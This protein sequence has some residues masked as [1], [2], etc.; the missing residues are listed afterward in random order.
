[1][2]SFCQCGVRISVHSQAFSVLS[3]Y[4]FASNLRRSIMALIESTAVR[5][6]LTCWLHSSILQLRRR[7]VS[8]HVNCLTFV[9]TISYSGCW[10]LLLLMIIHQTNVLQ[11]LVIHT[12]RKIKFMLVDGFNMPTSQKKVIIPMAA[13]LTFTVLDV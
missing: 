7:I 1:L 13:V 4:R 11:S 9:C 10:K 3:Q 2:E 6:P 12:S 8:V 5:A